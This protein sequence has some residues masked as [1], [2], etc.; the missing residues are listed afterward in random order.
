MI[1]DQYFVFSLL[2]RDCPGALGWLAIYIKQWEGKKKK[3]HGKL[4]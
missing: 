2:L 3:M 4:P 1:G